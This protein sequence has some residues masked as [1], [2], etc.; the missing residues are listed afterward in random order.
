MLTTAR[1]EF[2][3]IGASLRLHNRSVLVAR[4]LSEAV[5]DQHEAPWDELGKPDPLP[6]R[7]L[8]RKNEVITDAWIAPDLAPGVQVAIFRSDDG[9]YWQLAEVGLGWAYVAES[10]PHWP[11]WEPVQKHL[12]ATVA[13]RPKHDSDWNY[14]LKFSTGLELSVEMDTSR[15]AI[16]WE[17]RV[18]GRA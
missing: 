16:L 11:H 15:G 4:G 13:A 3:R 18:A 1:A 12:P 17:V 6:S 5:I 7:R 9:Q 8:P 2:D 10:E 14:V